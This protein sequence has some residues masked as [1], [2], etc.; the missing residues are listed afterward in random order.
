MLFSASAVQIRDSETNNLLRFQQAHLTREKLLHHSLFD[1]DGF[2]SAVFQ[3]CY[4]SIHI[5]ED[6]ADGDGATV[7]RS[8]IQHVVYTHVI[9]SH[10]VS[11]GHYIFQTKYSCNILDSFC[12][13][14][15]DF[16]S[17]YFHVRK[18]YFTYIVKT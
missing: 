4:L 15:D 1:G 18:L 16:V 13:I 9:F 2:V 11:N 10:D 17:V 12:Y 8:H 6:S 14:V 3:C 5:G 7:H